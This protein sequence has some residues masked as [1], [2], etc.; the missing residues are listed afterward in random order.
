MTLSKHETYI[1]IFPL[2]RFI[3]FPCKRCPVDDLASSN[4]S[5]RDKAATELRATFLDT[6]ETKWTNTIEALKKGQT[7]SEVL[8]LLRPFGVTKEMGVGRG[9]SQSQSY[10]LDNEWILICSFKNEGNILIGHQLVRQLK[11]IW[12]APDK[13]FTGKWIVYY[14]NGHKS[15]EI[16]YKNGAYFGEFIA[17]YSNG[18]KAYVQHH[19]LDGTDGEYTGYYPS[20]AVSYRGQYKAGKRYGTWTWYDES[21]KIKSTQDHPNP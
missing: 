8:E 16:N 1:H 5:V 9:Q 6:P 7:E 14:V 3:L 19:T 21:G 11:D 18:S 20:G 13:N 2:H 15:R 17:Y 10:R 4:Q 12:V